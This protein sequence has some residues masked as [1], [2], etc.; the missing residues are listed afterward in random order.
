MDIL[1]TDYCSLAIVSLASLCFPL[2]LPDFVGLLES[3]FIHFLTYSVVATIL[4]DT[5]G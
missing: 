2:C 4:L 3:D 1:F 5:Q